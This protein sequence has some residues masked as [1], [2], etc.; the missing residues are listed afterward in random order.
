MRFI[1]FVTPDISSMVCSPTLLALIMQLTF[2][3]YLSFSVNLFPISTP[4]HHFWPWTNW[5]SFPSSQKHSCCL[6]NLRHWT[7]PVLNHI[8]TFHIAL[9]E[10]LSKYAFWPFKCLSALNG[11]KCCLNHNRALLLA[12]IHDCSPFYLSLIILWNVLIA[13]L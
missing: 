5:S 11:E 1:R 3:I 12:L 10:S 9:K 13:L 6:L 7:Y 2:R 4:L 8:S